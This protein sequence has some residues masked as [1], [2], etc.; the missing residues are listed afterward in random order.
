MGPSDLKLL[1]II[2]YNKRQTWD[3]DGLTSIIL[4]QAHHHSLLQAAHTTFSTKA[5]SF[6]LLTAL[7]TAL[8]YSPMNSNINIF[9]DSQCN[10]YISSNNE[11]TYFR[12]PITKNQQSPH[13]MACHLNIF[14]ALTI[15]IYTIPE[16][17]LTV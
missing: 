9:T 6:A 10:L 5:E 2:R 4:L 15:S 1:I 12:P 13:S 7:L 8:L 11:Q 16:W 3:S 17:A 14:A